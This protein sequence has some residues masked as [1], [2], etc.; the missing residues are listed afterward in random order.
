[1][2]S[3]EQEVLVKRA[4]T[5]GVSV[6]LFYCSGGFAPDREECR[7]KAADVVFLP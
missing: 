2:F 1:M 3:W 5:P 4:G 6:F 7:K